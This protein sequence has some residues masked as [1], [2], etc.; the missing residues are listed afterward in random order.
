MSI[1][2]ITGITSGLDTD[3]MIEDLMD[4]EKLK[5]DKVEREKT[6]T[7]WEQE[8][9][10]EVID[11][12]SA[13]QSEYFDYLNP[14]T[15][16]RSTGAF[17]EF[18]ES[19]QVAGEDVSYVTVTGTMSIQ[20]YSHTIGSI[21]QLA[22]RDEWTTDASGIGNLS[23][24][25]IDLGSRP[26]EIEISLTI[27]DNT[28][29][30]TVDTS[31]AN[32]MNK[33]V[34]ALDDAI[35]EAFGSDYAGVVQESASG[36]SVYFR[37]DGSEVTIMETTGNES[38]LTW[39][40]FTSG[41]SSEDYTSEGIGTLLDVSEADLSDMTINGV[42]LADLG[43]TVDSTISELEEAIASDDTINADF[44]YSDM[45]DTFSLIS[46]DYGSANDIDMSA[47]FMSKLGFVDDV[48]HHDEGKNAIFELDGTT[49]IKSSN[50]FTMEGVK[51]ELN[52]VY[53]GADGDIDIKVENDIDAVKE[54]IEAFV[55]T[56]NGLIETLNDK[57][58]ETRDYDYE[59][60]T[61]E[62]K[63]ALSDEEIEK[64]EKYAKLGIL[65]NDSTISTMLSS[66]RTA[67][68]ESVEGVGLS[69]SDIGIQTSSNYK[70]GGKL[71]IDDD[72]LTAALENNF[73]D[74]VALFSNSSDKE[75]LDTD[76]ASERYRENGIANRLN[77]IL[78]NNIRTTRDSGGLKGTL[79]EKAG[80]TG[81][82]TEYDNSLTEKLDDYE[83]RIDALWELYYDK[84]DALYLKF[85]NMEAALAELQSQSSSLASTL[86]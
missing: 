84:E 68:Y 51:Y 38:D 79:L 73:E 34:T 13:F 75:Y 86:G 3:T 16:L 17:G 66:M 61:D 54:K 21:S 10:R 4:I 7:E 85:A 1:T 50:T 39:L 70:D 33:L 60:L 69:L 23:G 14:D 12:L 41:D 24:G 44:Y 65:H 78:Q 20:N 72:E 58:D 5:I 2:R 37:L 52:S 49:V 35:T 57:L 25:T 76:N 83:D 22:T 42:S 74:V 15:N 19:A 43:L 28:K 48:D 9:Y 67:L 45:S 56:Y 62:E 40:G 30:L 26:N 81:D 59:P 36:D 53:D 80:M 27:D 11:S 29:V 82:V 8:A 46:K 6:Y 32:T 55:Q 64:W 77:D 71:V 31:A 18:T 63:E 47:T